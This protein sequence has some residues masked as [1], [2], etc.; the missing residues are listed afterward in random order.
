MFTDASDAGSHLPRLSGG[1]TR[2]ATLSI[3]AY[4]DIIAVRA[5]CVKQ[6]GEI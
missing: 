3:I 4:V 2:S 6:D 1:Q 5:G